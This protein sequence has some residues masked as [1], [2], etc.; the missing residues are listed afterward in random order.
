MAKYIYWFYIITYSFA[1]SQES[2]NM[3][4]VGQL[5]YP[6][7]AN[8]IWG[9]SEGSNEYALVGVYDGTSIVNLTGSPNEL[10]F[11]PGA[12]TPKFKIL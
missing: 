5:D 10:F 1:S 2:L 9:Y 8:D 11:I 12:S 4:L 3:E 6:Q 7:G